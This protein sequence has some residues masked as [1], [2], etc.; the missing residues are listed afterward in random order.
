MIKKGSR[1]NDPNSGYFTLPGGKLESDEKGLNNPTGRIKSAAREVI[2]E[3]GIEIINPILKGVILFDNSERKFDNW[4][5]PDNFTVYIYSAKKYKGK[6]KKSDEGI[7]Y[8]VPLNKTPEVPSNPGDKKM[9]EWL[10]TG[11]RFFGVI[12]HK[13]KELDESGTWVDYF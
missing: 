4:K 10:N 3:A 11:K 7:P 9:Y 13:G 2:E 12:K 5:N 6:A 8:A 1:E